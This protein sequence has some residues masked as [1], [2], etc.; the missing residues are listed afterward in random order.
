[1]ALFKRKRGE[2]N[3][4]MSFIDHLEALRWHLI[5]SVIAILVGAIVIFI[6]VEKVTDVV[7]MGPAHKDFPTYAGLCN[8]GHKLHIGNALCMG[9]FQ[10]KFQSNAMTEQFMT[11]FTI[12]FVG[13]FIIAFPFVFWEFWRFVKPALSRKE[14]RKTRGIIFW[15]SAL[16][17]M[18]VAFGYYIL[19]PFMINF[20]STYSLSP[21]LIEFKPTLSDYIE[22]LIYTTVGI[23]V[24]FQM[25]LLV[26][27]L[28][29]I[30]IVTP[31]FLKKYRRHAF[32]VI[33]ILAAI[34]TPST[35]PFSLTLVTI[36]L[37]ALYEASIFVA[38]KVYKEREKRDA[39]EWS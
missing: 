25:P 6:Y 9:D 1:M 33:L 15:V 28:A 3:A 8:L 24:L 22:N 4:E 34:I 32:V 11:S 30:G 10:I 14:I 13:G 16:F 27:F 19:T 21:T 23:G 36:P 17:F 2:E 5:R 39:E 26:M 18:G 12:A 35:D 37:Y 20:Y 7:I 31:K 29:K 38:S